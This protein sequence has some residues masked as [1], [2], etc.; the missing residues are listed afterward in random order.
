MEKVETILIDCEEL[1]S[2]ELELEA[3]LQNKILLIENQKQILQITSV[4]EEREIIQK[5]EA[6]SQKEQEQLQE[7]IF[8]NNYLRNQLSKAEEL[9]QAQIIQTPPNFKK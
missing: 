2:W 4:S 3:R 8:T 5:H 7:E 6:I 1:V 9:T